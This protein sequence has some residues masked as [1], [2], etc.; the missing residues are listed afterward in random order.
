MKQIKAIL[1][2]LALVLPLC[3]C[4][5]IT[6]F[7]PGRD[8]QTP[9]G[10]AASLREYISGF[11]SSLESMTIPLS[12][13][14]DG[15][16]IR[17]ITAHDIEID[18]RQYLEEVFIAHFDHD[19]GNLI[20]SRSEVR[21]VESGSTAGAEADFVCEENGESFLIISAAARSDSDMYLLLAFA[22]EKDAERL[23]EMVQKMLA[24]YQELAQ[25]GNA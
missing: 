25:S 9:Q 5:T 6:S 19:K 12:M 16:F 1:L 2:T 22:A 20:T 4:G 14:A 8:R 11:E 10:E 21:S 15:S 3:G 17:V 7:G 23:K 13:S 24:E 18:A